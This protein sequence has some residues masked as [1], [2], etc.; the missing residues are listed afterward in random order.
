MARTVI[1]HIVGEDPVVGE[2]E[3]PPQPTDQFVHLSNARRRDGKEVAYLAP[4]CESVLF[5]WGRITFVEFMAE[6]EIHRDVL[7]FFRLD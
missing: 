2:I 7:D 5:P 3:E 1:V 6:E 4:G